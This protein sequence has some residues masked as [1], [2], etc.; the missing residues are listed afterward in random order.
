MRRDRS[1][2]DGQSKCELGLCICLRYGKR[3]K[4]LHAGFSS[5]LGREP[6]THLV[7]LGSLCGQLRHSRSTA[8]PHRDDGCQSRGRMEQP[9]F[10]RER[11]PHTDCQHAVLDGLHHRLKHDPAGHRGW[12][13]SRD[14]VGKRVHKCHAG[15]RGSAQSI[16]S[17]RRNSLLLFHVSDS[18]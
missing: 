16:W 13:L 5:V 2:W 18:E 1:N 12:N 14:R 4:R 15:E 3:C 17:N 11:L 8:L 9:L 10:D 7:R 6:Y